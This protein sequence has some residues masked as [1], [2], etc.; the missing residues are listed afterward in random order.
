MALT[1][2][3]TIS[4][5]Q[6][7]QHNFGMGCRKGAIQLPATHS[8]S[9]KASLQADPPDSKAFLANNHKCSNLF[10]TLHSR[11]RHGNTE[12]PQLHVQ[13]D[14]AASLGFS[15][16]DMCP[17]ETPQCSGNYGF[18]SIRVWHG[19]CLSRCTSTWLDHDRHGST[20]SAHH[21]MY[22]DMSVCLAGH[23]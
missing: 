14:T 10:A 6:A 18:W 15:W 1:V 3:H 13:A 19:H 2:G 23:P 4:V 7:G 12:Y 11:S 20:R 21:G 5:P 17:H 16:A 8:T 9:V 22:D